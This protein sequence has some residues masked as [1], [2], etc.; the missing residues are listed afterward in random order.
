MEFEARI[1]KG[2][3]NRTIWRVLVCVLLG[4]KVREEFY[5]IGF[6]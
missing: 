1:L 3:E 5:F 6:L 4:I 2:F